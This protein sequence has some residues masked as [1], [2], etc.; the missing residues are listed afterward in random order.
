M[1]TE[2]ISKIAE[3]AI[4]N[5]IVIAYISNLLDN[6]ESGNLTLNNFQDLFNGAETAE[7]Y[8]RKGEGFC[9]TFNILKV[10]HPEKSDREIEK[11]FS[12]FEDISEHALKL[13]IKGFKT[14]ER[15]IKNIL[16]LEY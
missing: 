2:T 14:A 7:N 9:T 4:N 13:E 12:D 3:L 16:F 11:M 1:K 8:A 6:V 15:I 10:N 5:E